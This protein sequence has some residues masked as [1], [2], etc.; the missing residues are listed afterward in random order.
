M[1]EYDP[2]R[3]SNFGLCCHILG[4]AGPGQRPETL[5]RR[6][7]CGPAGAQ[8]PPLAQLPCGA[9]V[10]AAGA[11]DK[12]RSAGLLTGCPEGLLALT[13]LSRPRIPGRRAVH[14]KCGLRRSEEIASTCAGIRAQ[15]PY[16]RIYMTDVLDMV[17]EVFETKGILKGNTLVTVTCTRLPAFSLPS[18]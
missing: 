18:G 3:G 14:E 16:C 8:S 2:C 17:S 15:A 10:P 13:D 12:N 1:S 4:A 11:A 9:L 6:R 7:L 5:C